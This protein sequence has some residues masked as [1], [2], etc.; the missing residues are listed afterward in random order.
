[1]AMR[2]I[3]SSWILLG[4]I[5]ALLAATAKASQRK[6]LLRLSASARVSLGFA[7]GGVVQVINERRLW[8]GCFG[9][10]ASCFLAWVGVRK[11]NRDPEGRTPLL[12]CSEWTTCKVRFSASST[13][14]F[15]KTPFSDNQHP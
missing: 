2:V 5:F 15:P 4:L 11:Y 14:E 6:G 7:A 1:M 9:L 3:P 13:I 12:P 8:P 10:V